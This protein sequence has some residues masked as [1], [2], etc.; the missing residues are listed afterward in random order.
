MTGNDIERSY[1]AAVKNQQADPTI[2]KMDAL[3]GMGYLLGA[4][5]TGAAAA[6]SALYATQYGWDDLPDIVKE[7]EGEP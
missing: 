6:M 1:R 7:M 3:L 4:G 5:M 2:I